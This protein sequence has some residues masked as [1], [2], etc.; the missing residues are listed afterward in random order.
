MLP[1]AR[2]SWSGREGGGGGGGLGHQR[3]LRQRP[4]RGRPSPLRR[5][6]RWGGRRGL[7]ARVSALDKRPAEPSEGRP[8]GVQSPARYCFGGGAGG[9]CRPAPPRPRG[10]VPGVGAVAAEHCREPFP[11]P[12]TERLGGRAGTA[13]KASRSLLPARPPSAEPCPCRRRRPDRC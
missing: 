6:P 1:R 5:R 2:P 11:R 7:P 13:G 9:G 4:L 8:P 3:P 10:H 12:R